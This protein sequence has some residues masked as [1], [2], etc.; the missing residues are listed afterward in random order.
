MG[1]SVSIWMYMKSG[2]FKP[3]GLM[4][5]F[6]NGV[7]ILGLA[8]AGHTRAAAGGAPANYTGKVVDERGQP[9]AG[10]TVEC[11][12]DSSAETA[13]TAQDF[14]LKERSTTDSKG[15]FGVAAG[16]RVTFVV[17][18][19]EGLAP[20]W[21]TWSSMLDD[22]PDPVI[23]TAPTALAG[24][25]VD[26]NNQPVAGAEVWVSDAMAGDPQTRIFGK[27]ARENFSA[28]TGADGR[29]RIENFPADGQATLAVRKEGK[30]QRPV[31]N[32]DDLG[33]H[34]RS[35]QE[36]VELMVGR[37]GSVEGKVVVAET[38]QPVGG[39]GIQLRGWGGGLYGTEFLEPIESGTDGVFRISDLQ[40]GKYYVI[41]TIPG[42]PIPDWVVVQE[43]RREVTVVAGKTTRDEVVHVT[44]GALL[45]VTVV[46]TNDQKP[47]ANVKLSTGHYAGTYTDANGVA[48]L[49]AEPGK[50]FFSAAKNGWS[51]QSARPV[52]EGGKTNFYM[53]KLIPLPIITGTVR[54]SSGAP[55]A[56]VMVSFHPGINQPVE[57]K[58]DVDGHYELTIK[59]DMREGGMWT[60]PSRQRSFVIARSLERNLAAMQEFDVIPARLDF[61]LQPAITISGSVKDTTG[62]P[63]PGATAAPSL[64]WGKQY[65]PLFSR[66]VKVDAQ[67]LFTFAGLPQGQEYDFLSGITAKGYG[68]SFGK[69][70]VSASAAETNHYEIPPFVLKKADR[71]LAGKVLGPDGKPLAGAMVQLSGEGQPQ[72]LSARSNSKGL[73][74]IDGVCEGEVHLYASWSY[75]QEFGG[76][77]DFLNAGNGMGI[78]AQAGDTNFVIQMQNPNINAGYTLTF[79]GT[80]FDPS[81][82]PARDLSVSV[83]PDMVDMIQ[84][85]ALAEPTATD[86]DGKYT[87]SRRQM[88]R[89][90]TAYTNSIIVRDEDHNLVAAHLFDENTTN[91]DLRL[92]PGLTISAKV[93]DPAGKSISNLTAKLQILVVGNL[94][95]MIPSR[96]DQTEVPGRIEFKALPRGYRYR[97]FV[98]APGYGSTTRPVTLEAA[99]QANRLDLPNVVLKPAKLKVAGHVVDANG[100][101]V[102]SA[103]VS[104]SGDGQPTTNTQSD[105]SGHFALD[106]CE[107]PLTVTG[108]V[109]GAT[110]HLQTLGG[111]TNIS[112][113]LIPWPGAVADPPARSVHLPVN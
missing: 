101:A 67:G 37:A 44:K 55:V 112:L 41:A 94:W 98:L 72:G 107:G 4:K 88:R 81:G 90:E 86:F 17:V 2:I 35:G 92:Q 59:E 15:G 39:V 79:S 24:S 77:P 84:H 66:P 96:T 19:K 63:L 1:L 103:W 34:A 47:V 82:A 76:Q 43:D 26:E 80:V 111:E 21:K 11:Y 50:G 87:V 85:I 38:G 49:R 65:A 62:A 99:T 36:D 23:L 113:K 12:Q 91:L 54:D 5:I 13:S 68:T 110:G 102:P 74:V 42:Q 73:F 14:V 83:V 97:L 71:K 61:R 69:N 64:L 7:F 58:T 89:G 95:Q 32:S 31:G 20:G 28:K 57:V 93:E 70:Q 106:V 51:L 16:S 48:L 8:L 29:F 25:V 30:A 18:K 104:V 108:S 100:W 33:A 22:S 45:R 6:R 9:L 60:G 46:N 105:W 3:E 10:A 56:G 27:P 109:Q 52:L 75:T 53:M 78:K 40:P